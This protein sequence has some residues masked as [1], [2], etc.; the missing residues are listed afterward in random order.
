MDSRIILVLVLEPIRN[1]T[2]KHKLLCKIPRISFSSNT[3]KIGARN[4]GE[5]RDFDAK[6]LRHCPRRQ[7]QTGRAIRGLVGSVVHVP[8]RLKSQESIR[9]ALLSCRPG[10]CP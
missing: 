9:Q 7:G 5:N 2:D 1:K 4:L 8:C 6:V 10:V 3:S